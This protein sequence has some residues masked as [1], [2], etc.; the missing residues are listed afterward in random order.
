MAS[1]AL[2]S[3]ARAADGF[4][5]ITAGPGQYKLYSED[6]AASD[7]WIYNGGLP[8]PEIRVRRGERVK[9]R[10]INALEEATSIHWHGVRIDNAMDGVSGLTQD[11]VPPGGTFEYDFVAPDAGTY[12]YHAHNKSWNQVG[13]GLYGPLIIEEDDPVFDRDHDLMLIM[14]DWRLN[15]DGR[16]DTA[17]FGSLMDWSHAGRLGNWLTVNGKSDPSFSLNAGEAY[18]IRLVN[19]SNARVLELDPDRIGG[20]V[21][22]YDGQVLTDAEQTTAQ[23]LV[24]APAQRVD[25]VVVPEAGRDLA[26]VEVSTSQ[27]FA[28]AEFKVTGDGKGNPPAR[29]PQANTL[30][31][32]DLSNAKRI[33]LDMT[34]GAMGQM[35]PMRHKG[36]MMTRD[37]IR[38][39]GQVWAFNGIA[40]VDEEPLFEAARGETVLLETINNT[41]W[42]H[43]IHLH[44]HHF[45]TVGA[46]GTLGPWRDTFLIERGETVKVAFQADNPGKWLFHCHML[47]HAAAGMTTWIRVT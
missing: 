38:A 14:D 22:G 40:N 25:L 18:R 21:I 23:A 30:P 10:L 47:E 24:I 39:T 46:D 37:D 43:A 6:A 26:L 36:L 11:P 12:W 16:L 7:L 1:G 15:D 42:P 31:A 13:R 17:S 45:R 3:A 44:G 34:G 35:G 41:A 27:R 28:F 2:F 4:F 19:A 33:V 9:V 8:G 32:P 5:E 29:L 20:Q